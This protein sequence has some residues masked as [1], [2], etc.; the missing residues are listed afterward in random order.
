MFVDKKKTLPEAPL[1]VKSAHL[2]LDFNHLKWRR[3]GFTKEP[4]ETDTHKTLCPR[5]SV[6][7][8]NRGHRCLA[9]L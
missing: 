2:A 1:A 5:Q 4:G 7:F 8:F 9:L 3:D 6:V